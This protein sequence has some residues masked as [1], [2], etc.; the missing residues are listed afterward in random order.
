PSFWKSGDIFDGDAEADQSCYW[1]N[2]CGSIYTAPCPAQWNSFVQ[3]LTT[4][5]QAAFATIGVKGV[6]YWIHSMAH[7][8]IDNLLTAQTLAVDHNVLGDD[9]YPDQGQT[10]PNVAAQKWQARLTAMHS[11]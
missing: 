8:R 7:D 5:A 9:E 11:E 3:N 10:D 4:Y 6:R 1:V 2:A